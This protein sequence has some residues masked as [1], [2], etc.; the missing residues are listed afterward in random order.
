MQRKRDRVV[1]WA[2]AHLASTG[3][4]QE[5]GGGGEG[6]VNH[7]ALT[8]ETDA[9]RKLRSCLSAEDALQTLPRDYRTRV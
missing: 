6:S 9:V 3:T 4:G 2:H 5:G 8:S 7:T 1:D